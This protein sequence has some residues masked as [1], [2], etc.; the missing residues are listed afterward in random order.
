MVLVVVTV[1]RDAVGGEVS[2]AGSAFKASDRPRRELAGE[3][4]DPEQLHPVG[5]LGL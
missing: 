2:S 4:T 1:V 5:A 3:V